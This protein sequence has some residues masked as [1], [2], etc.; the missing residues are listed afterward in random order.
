MAIKEALGCGYSQREWQKINNHHD[1]YFLFVLYVY[2]DGFWVII[3][4]GPVD[5][6]EILIQKFDKSR[7]NIFPLEQEGAA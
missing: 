6:L 7:S 2:S 3:V 5:Y 1:A 4:N